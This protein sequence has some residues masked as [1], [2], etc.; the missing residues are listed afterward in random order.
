MSI[1][2]SY[3]LKYWLTYIESLSFNS[4]NFNLKKIRKVAQKLDLINWSIPVITITGTNGKGTCAAAIEQMYISASYRVGLFNSPYFSKYEEQIRING[5]DIDEISLCHAF[6]IVEQHRG[7][8]QLTLFEFTT[9]AALLIFKNNQLDVIILEVG[10]GGLHDA[11]NIIPPDLAII[12]NVEI[13]HTKW[14]G[15]TREKIAIEK[16]GIVRPKIPVI[17]SDNKPIPK[18]ALNQLHIKKARLYQLGKDFD[19]PTLK[20]SISLS[21]TSVAA[22]IKAIKI[23]QSKLPVKKECIEKGILKTKL[24]NRFEVIEYPVMQVFDVAHNPSAAS[25]LAEKLKNQGK[26]HQTIAVFSMLFD[27]DIKGTIEPLMNIVDQWYIS[28]LNH[29]RAATI[30]QLHYAFHELNIKSYH[31]YQSIQQAYQ[32]A[33]NTTHENDRII[34]F[35]SFKMF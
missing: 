28:A 32:A 3:S 6:K 8:I 15:E 11:V 23:L 19:C 5:I 34:I 12:T 26:Y 25:L 21:K 30:D 17:Y 18:I 10:M 27:K 29:Q 35:G 33:L 2:Q 22:A 31:Q 1:P 7:A 4:I 20:F 14:L 16:F 9:L 24:P 13:D